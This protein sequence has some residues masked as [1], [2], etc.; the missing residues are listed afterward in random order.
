MRLN[1]RG[2][3]LNKDK[4]YVAKIMEG[5]NKKN[6]HCPCRVKATEST[7]CP[8]DEFVKKGICVCKLFIKEE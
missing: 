5:I 7:L 6:G 1:M 3:R 4:E 8:C 2:Y